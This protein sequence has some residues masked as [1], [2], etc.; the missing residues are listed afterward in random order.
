[1]S[2]A[3]RKGTLIVVENEI[4]AVYLIVVK[5]A[6]K[7]EG[8]QTP[9]TARILATTLYLLLGMINQFSLTQGC[10][11]EE[12]KYAILAIRIIYE[13]IRTPIGTCGGDIKKVRKNDAAVAAAAAAA[14]A[15]GATT[16]TLE[17]IQ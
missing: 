7:L 15:T 1:M 12:V 11:A 4:L 10:A 5:S 2:N 16:A 14:A 6:L 8:V 13:V 17:A 3:G 9:E